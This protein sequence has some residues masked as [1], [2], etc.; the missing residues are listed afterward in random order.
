MGFQ[1]LGWT[2]GNVLAYRLS[3]VIFPEDYERVLKPEIKQ[4]LKKHKQFNLIFIVSLLAQQLE[5]LDLTCV[6]KLEQFDGASK[7]SLWENTKFAMQ[8]ASSMRK[9]AIVGKHVCSLWSRL[10][11]N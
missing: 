1:R 9:M 3:G 8:M 10:N 11:G 4:I 6:L 7:D 5:D 2:S